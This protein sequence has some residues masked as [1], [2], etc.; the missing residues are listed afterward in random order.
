MIY[1]SLPTT[2]EIQ[3]SEDKK[4]SICANLPNNTVTTH[5]KIAKH[6]HY[7]IF[8]NSPWWFGVAQNII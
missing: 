6:F 8:N 5:V 2:L 3:I 4:G 1:I 7:G